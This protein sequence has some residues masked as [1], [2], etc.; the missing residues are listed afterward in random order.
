MLCNKI[1]LYNSLTLS[2]L[3]LFTH[4]QFLKTTLSMTYGNLNAQV[5]YE[6]VS[7]DVELQYVKGLRFVWNLLF[8]CKFI[9]TY[10]NQSYYSKTRR[11]I[12]YIK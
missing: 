6:Y 11:T 1:K 10:C 5:P 7:I 4:F 9:D 2:Y 3:G 12:M 8:G